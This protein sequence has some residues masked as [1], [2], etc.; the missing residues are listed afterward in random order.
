MKLA[1][2]LIVGG[3][4]GQLDEFTWKFCIKRIFGFVNLIKTEYDND[5]IV[6]IDSQ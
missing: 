2:K 5:E 6:Q 1:I 4:K 3:D